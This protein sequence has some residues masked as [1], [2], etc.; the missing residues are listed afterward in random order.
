MTLWQKYTVLEHEEFQYASEEKLLRRTAKASTIIERV[1]A[2]ISDDSDQSLRK[3]AL[4]VIMVSESTM[5]R[6]VKKDL[7]HKSHIKDTTDLAL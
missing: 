3:L 1:E 4:L 5:C 7:R 6:I 2:L